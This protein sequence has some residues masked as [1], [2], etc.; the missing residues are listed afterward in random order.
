MRPDWRVY[1]SSRLTRANSTK[2][3]PVLGSERGVYGMDAAGARS[4]NLCGVTV[5]PPIAL[6]MI[7]LGKGQMALGTASRQGNAYRASESRLDKRKA[8]GHVQPPISCAAHK[9]A[10]LKRKITSSSSLS[11]SLPSSP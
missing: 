9:V 3:S 6:G 11:F 5:L 10:T 8:A 7:Q 1:L 2:A 4:T